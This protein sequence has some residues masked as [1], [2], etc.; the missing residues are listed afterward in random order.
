MFALAAIGLLAMPAHAAV[1]S[2]TTGGFRIEQSVVVAATP[3]EAFD[4]FTG[5]VS[6]WWDHHFSEKPKALYIEPKPG[7]GFYEIF[8]EAG[9]GALH[10]TVIYV[11][12][13]KEIRF[14][15]P[16]GLSGTAIEFAQ[17]VTFTPEGTGKTKVSLV[18]DAAGHVDAGWPEAVDAVWHHFLVERFQPYVASGA[19]RTPAAAAP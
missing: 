13:G 8:D 10:A 16:M 1:T 14:S 5:D 4:A 18:V 11:M 2:T 7:G 6:P 15:G 3:D 17:T 12:A 9:N 19:F